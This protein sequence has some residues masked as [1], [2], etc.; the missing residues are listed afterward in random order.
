MQ[1]SGTFALTATDR[2]EPLYA[3]AYRAWIA[4]PGCPLSADR[5]GG[6]ENARLG[7]SAA[8]IQLVAAW[9]APQVVVATPSEQLV[10]AGAAE[11]PVIA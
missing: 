3:V 11:Q 2:Q 9:A 6:P 5:Q 8:L 1:V 4:R 10:A 7:L